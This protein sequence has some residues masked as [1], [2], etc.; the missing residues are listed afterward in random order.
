MSDRQTQITR[1]RFLQTTSAATA[2]GLAKSSLA[3]ALSNS[4][5]DTHVYLGHWPLSH[6]SPATPTELVT[7]LRQAGVTQAWAGTFDGLFHKDVHAANMRLVDACR[8]AGDDF[9]IPIGSVNPTLPDW[10]EDIRRCR[11][12]FKMPGIRLH[13]TYHGYALDDSRFARLL[14]AASKRGLF[15]QL[16]VQMTNERPRHLTPRD[17]QVDL[18]PLSEIAPRV[19][20]SPVIISNPVRL[21]DDLLKRL[22]MQMNTYFEF[23][24][25]ADASVLRHLVGHVSADRIVYGSSAPLFDVAADRITPQLSGVTAEQTNAI[26]RGNAERVV[27]PTRTTR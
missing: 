17:S 25:T 3:G 1:R 22:A 20:H 19:P 2:C 26:R 18:G 7:L 16:V 14:E 4:L 27:L 12:L 5:I 24:R 13:P 9:L 23:P 11:E 6:L 15:V 8:N 10:E 21:A